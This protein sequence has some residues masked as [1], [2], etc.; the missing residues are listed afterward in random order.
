ML[1]KKINN[2]IPTFFGISTVGSTVYVK[3]SQDGKS[4]AEKQAIVDSSSRFNITFAEK[5]PIGTYKIN[6]LATNKNNDYIEIPEFDL[7]ISK[8]KTSVLR[9]QSTPKPG[10][11]V[12]IIPTQASKP[13]ED[14]VKIEHCFL[15]WCW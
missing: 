6:I 15:W 4:V 9:L 10:S 8:P 12:E 11:G 7:T 1:S 14:T 2:Y 3:I 13:S 5:L